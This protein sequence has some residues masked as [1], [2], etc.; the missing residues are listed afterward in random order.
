MSVPI[1][2]G[3]GASSVA[4][5]L[6][7]G[8]N[9]QQIEVYG[10]GGAS[11]LNI[12]PDH[13]INV[14]ILG[15]PPV[16]IAGASSA[17]IAVVQRLDTQV[18]GS[19]LG[20]VTHAVL[21]GLTSA[22]GGVYVDVKVDPSGALV[23]SGGGSVVSVS[24]PGSVTAVRTDNA[25]VITTQI[26]GSIMAVAGAVS[27]SG[28]VITSIVNSI[29]S[30][31]LVG[32]S[33]FGQLPAGTAPLGSVATLQGTNPWVIVGSV[34]GSG[35]VVAFQG[36]AW[37]TSV[38]A[39]TITSVA[40]ANGGL[41]LWSPLGSRIQGTADFRGTQGASIA[42]IA[43]Q[44]SGVFTY[45]D[46]VQIANFG[47]SSVLVTIADNTTSIIG[48]TIAP[49]GGGSNFDAFL[50]GAANS[51]ITASLNGTASV[52]ISMQGFTSK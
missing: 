3:T 14:S 50:K 41:P 18:I 42:V 49:A 48:Y 38:V 52:L 22:G 51:P 28:T 24:Y 36:G 44:G 16:Q 43:A 27:Q 33:I 46:H 2:Q 11:V 5:E 25:S 20:L 21:H 34:Y 37:S 15:T 8:L 13:S 31:V 6:V 17:S 32:A 4:A 39:N 30:S 45:V 7:S 23:T 10:G 29:P 35:S 26:A 19:N 12:N 40:T 9:Y 1:T 47:T